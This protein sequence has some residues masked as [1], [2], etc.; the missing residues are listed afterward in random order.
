M[1]PGRPEAAVLAKLRNVYRTSLFALGFQQHGDIFRSKFVSSSV[2]NAFGGDWVSWP[3][4]VDAD[5]PELFATI[6]ELSPKVRG[7]QSIPLGQK[8]KHV[9][10]KIERRAV[11]R[12]NAN[13]EHRLEGESGIQAAPSGT[14][15]D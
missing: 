3:V 12:R 15:D 14:L 6:A 2:R 7:L 1:R 8:L 11:G 13:A 5:D 10:F 4:G 9:L